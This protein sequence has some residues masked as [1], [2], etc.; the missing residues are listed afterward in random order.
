MGFDMDQVARARGAEAV[1]ARRSARP[2]AGIGGY[3]SVHAAPGLP[4]SIRGARGR[5]GGSRGLR[6]VRAVKGLRRLMRLFD[7]VAKFKKTVTEPTH[8]T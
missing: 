2:G 7:D 3:R 1:V 5:I 8:K 6:A 4:N